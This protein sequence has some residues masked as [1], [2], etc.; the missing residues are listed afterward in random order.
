MKIIKR[1]GNIYLVKRDLAYGVWHTS[2]TLIGTYE[3]NEKP[4]VVK[5][6]KTKKEDK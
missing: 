1:D 4:K 2:E 5:T 6:K 3:E